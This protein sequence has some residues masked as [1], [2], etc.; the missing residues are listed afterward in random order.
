MIVIRFEMV[1]IRLNM[2]LVRVTNYFNTT[3]PIEQIVTLGIIR[4]IMALCDENRR[5]FCE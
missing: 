5:P 3:R 2:I 4:N 1:S